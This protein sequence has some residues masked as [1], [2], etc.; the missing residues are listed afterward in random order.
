MFGFAAGGDV[1]SGIALTLVVCVTIVLALVSV[2]R[3]NRFAAFCLLT[4]SSM[5]A[6]FL[7]YELF[8]RLRG[9]G[10]T[11]FID[12][13]AAKL[14]SLYIVVPVMAL[15]FLW[16]TAYLYLRRKRHET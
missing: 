2:I 7:T 11:Y 13:T 5:P 6:A 12:G 16:G 10:L 3:P 1:A 8:S 4:I 15:P 14:I 9:F